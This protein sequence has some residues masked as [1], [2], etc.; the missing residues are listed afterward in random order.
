MSH[1]VFHRNS[2]SQ[3]AGRHFREDHGR[4]AT[5]SDQLSS[6]PTRSN[7]DGE[8]FALL[9]MCRIALIAWV[10]VLTGRV[11]GAGEGSGG[12]LAKDCRSLSTVSVSAATWSAS[13]FLSAASEANC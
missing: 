3:L 12:A 8:L 10:L 2:H 1:F 7:Q 4:R 9:R 13:R 6:D 11:S 5:S